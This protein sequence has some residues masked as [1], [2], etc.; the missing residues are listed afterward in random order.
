MYDEIPNDEDLKNA[1]KRLRKAKKQYKRKQIN[2]FEYNK[3][4]QEYKDIKEAI[5][6]FNLDWTGGTHV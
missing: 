1:E 3:I 2:L 5:D 6:D 4:K